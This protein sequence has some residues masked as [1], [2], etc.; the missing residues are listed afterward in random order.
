MG[1]AQWHRCGA[2]T[3][4]HMAGQVLEGVIRWDFYPY[5]AMLS[6]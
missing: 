3:A 4:Q 2:E 5:S 1:S 6:K